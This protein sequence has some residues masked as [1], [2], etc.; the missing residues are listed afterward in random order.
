MKEGFENMLCCPICRGG[1]SLV[2]E[3]AV[4]VG[5]RI[6]EGEICCH[7]H[8]AVF[9]VVETVV[10]EEFR[11]NQ[12]KQDVQ[13]FWSKHPCMGEWENEKKQFDEVRE[14]RYRT[15]PWLHR[16]VFEFGSHSEDVILEIGCSQGI[17]M[18]EFLRAGVRGYIG[19]DLTLKGLLLA[20]RRLEYCGLY[21]LD[22]NLLCADAEGLALADSQVDYVYSYGVIHHSE[23]TQR[24]I[25]HI[26]RVLKPGGAFTVMYYY[27]YSLTTLIEGTAK[28]INRALSFITRDKDA[29][30][31]LCKLLPYK[32]EIGHYRKFLDTGYSAI[33][34]A[35]FAHMYGKRESRRM[36]SAFSIRQMK[37][38][39]LSPVVRPTIRSLFGE[40][41]VDKL[42]EWMGW[43]LVING[44]KA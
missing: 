18:A 29:F 15:H 7:E 1:V 22:V 28:F 26:Y 10:V 3:T 4:K 43:D 20:R 25:N 30:W 38:Y 33:L 41:A 40:R 21:D 17:D 5:G 6:E 19:L 31:K 44:R 13:E 9:R 36:F 42:A 14:Y 11:L 2:A 23:N 35:P 37:V 34:H 32:P 24:I 27:K 16:E 8:G 39:Q 12:A